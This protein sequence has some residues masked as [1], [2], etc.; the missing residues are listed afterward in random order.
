MRDGR[1]SILVFG[2]TGR[3]GGAV[4]RALLQRRWLVRASVRDAASPRAAALRDAGIELVQGSFS[5]ADVIRA[6]MQDVHGVFSMQ[7]SSTGGTGAD[8]QEMRF[9]MAIADLAAESG[10]AH[11]VYSSGASVGEKPTGVA[12][13]DSKLRIEAHIRTL[14]LTATIVRPMIFMEMLARP[15]LGLEQGLFRFFLGPDQPLQLVAVDDIGKVVAAIFADRARFGGKTLKIASD[16]VTG[17]QLA[18]SFSEIA[19]R[20]IAY[21]RFPDEVLA[22][23]P[24]L[25]HMAASLEAGPLADHADLG[26][27]REIN[28]QIASFRAWLAGSGRQ[29]LDEVLGKGGKGDRG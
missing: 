6:A 20:P 14:P 29:A 21:M 1:D 23:N 3:Q 17:R 16:T 11:F 28:P 9:G 19:G 18:A 27:M 5:D 25:R 13:F 22:A 4:A 15:G 26:V 2:A 7:P 10:V 8:T 12:R 24:D